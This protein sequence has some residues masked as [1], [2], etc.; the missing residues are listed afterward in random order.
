MQSY[1][2]IQENNKFQFLSTQKTFQFDYL[3]Q[4]N[5]TIKVTFNIM[6]LNPVHVSCNHTK[7]A[8]DCIRSYQDPKLLTSSIFQSPR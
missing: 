4:T 6:F 7:P 5:V 8:P 3:P 2:S 1:E